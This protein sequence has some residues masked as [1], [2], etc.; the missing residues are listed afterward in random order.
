MLPVRE[1]EGDCIEPGHA[2]MFLLPCAP[3]RGQSPKKFR[4][5]A[6]QSGGNLVS[7]FATQIAKR[8]S[9]VIVLDEED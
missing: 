2:R 8:L 4:K 7:G 3:H 9:R 5:N 6:G 1:S